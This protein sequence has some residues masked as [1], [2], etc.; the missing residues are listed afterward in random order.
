MRGRER[1]KMGV[2]CENKWKRRERLGMVCG[3]I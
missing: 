1:G 3:K 2:A